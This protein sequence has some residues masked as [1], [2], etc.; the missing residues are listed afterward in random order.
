MS[1]VSSCS[2]SFSVHDVP[3]HVPG[4]FYFNQL[5]TS[6]WLANQ[7]GIPKPWGQTQKNLGMSPQQYSPKAKTAWFR[8]LTA[9]ATPRCASSDE[10]WRRA[11]QGGSWWEG[12][13]GE[14]LE[15]AWP[16]FSTVEKPQ[17][18]SPKRRR[19]QGGSVPLCLVLHFL[20]LERKNFSQWVFSS[21]SLKNCF[22]VQIPS[23]KLPLTRPNAR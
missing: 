11:G 22:H 5:V 6:S 1:D 2:K 16:H 21:L 15:W 8:L 7:P 12:P 17:Q 19:S 14:D 23:S 18:Y 13:E 10:G 3:K 9:I 20:Q 4:P